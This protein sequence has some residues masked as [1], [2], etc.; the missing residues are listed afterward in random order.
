[1]G[2]RFQVVAPP[3]RKG[4]KMSVMTMASVATRSK[5]ATIEV[6]GEGIRTKVPLPGEM[7]SVRDL[8]VAAGR[9][10]VACIL[11]FRAKGP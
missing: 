10:G 4:K 6:L 7:T 5:A 11:P 8:L 1:M 9:L 2:S 3:V